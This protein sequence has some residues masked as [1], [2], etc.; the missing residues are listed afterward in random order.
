MLTGTFFSLARPLS[1]TDFESWV[2]ALSAAYFS[3]AA[4]LTV[5]ASFTSGAESNS[6]PLLVWLVWALYGALL[7]LAI[8]NAMLFIFI[9]TRYT[10]TGLM[11]TPVS[12]LHR[13]MDL[14]GTFGT[15][16][17]VMLDA[18]IN[19]Q[20]YYGTY[21]AFCGA[22]AAWS[23][24]IFTAVWTLALDGVNERGEPYIYR[25]LNWHINVVK[26]LSHFVTPGK[27]I[28]VELFLFVPLFNALYWCMLWARRRARVAAKQSAV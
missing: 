22:A 12:Q 25:A 15:F 5:F 4:L 3:L 18:W 10:V 24:L 2:L 14:I 9:T 21:H 28:V 19:R 6:T 27:F 23:Y 8:L 1:L 26:D 17:M 20:P 7:P 13:V 11:T 16:L